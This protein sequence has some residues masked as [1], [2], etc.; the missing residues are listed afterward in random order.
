MFACEGRIKKHFS[1][2]TIFSIDLNS[3]KL[4]EGF[5]NI[6]IEHISKDAIGFVFLSHSKL[7]TKSHLHGVKIK[8]N[9]QI[10]EIKES[11]SMPHD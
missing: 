5:S 10:K 8:R 6:C 2:L 11:H 3:N 9:E 1:E 4:R 7:M